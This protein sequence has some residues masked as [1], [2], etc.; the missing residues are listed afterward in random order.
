MLNLH[1][2]LLSRK[3]GCTAGIIKLRAASLLCSALVRRLKKTSRLMRARK[4]RIS[5][6]SEPPCISLANMTARK[7]TTYN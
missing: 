1:K 2:S 5:S 4:K 7:K 3:T 6:A